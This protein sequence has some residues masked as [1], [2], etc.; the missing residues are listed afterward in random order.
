MLYPLSYRREGPDGI[1]AKRPAR[2][3][4]G[5]GRW[6]QRALSYVAEQP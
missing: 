3:T 2:E 4:A 5:H 1:P 6:F